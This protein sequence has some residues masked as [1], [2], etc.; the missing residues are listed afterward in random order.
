MPKP[1][2]AAE[3]EGGHAGGGGG[4]SA[5]GSQGHNTLAPVGAPVASAGKGPE[6]VG[7]MVGTPNGAAAGGGA[8]AGSGGGGGGA[9]QRGPAGKEHKANKALRRKKN[10]E[11][12]MG[13]VDAVVPV[14]G[15]DEGAETLEPAQRVPAAPAPRTPWAPTASVPQRPRSEQ[16]VEQTS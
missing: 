13:E 5:I 8:G 3:H 1:E 14:I 11:L 4:P 16:R 2:R 7:G 12:V 6:G 15:D 9:G 10:G